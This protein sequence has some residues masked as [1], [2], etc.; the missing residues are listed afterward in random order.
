MQRTQCVYTALRLESSRYIIF[1]LQM[2]QEHKIVFCTC[3]S[4]A[5]VQIHSTCV[6]VSVITSR[7]FRSI[8]CLLMDMPLCEQSQKE[9]VAVLAIKAS[10]PET[11]RRKAHR[12]RIM[13]SVSYTHLR[14][15]ETPEHLVCRLL[16]EKKKKKNH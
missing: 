1:I 15:H 12:E 10:D 9:E 4:E 6:F 13:K 14:A 16:L 11:L 5:N 7:H 2:L 3:S 8:Q